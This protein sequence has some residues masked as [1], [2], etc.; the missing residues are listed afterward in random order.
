M[1][2]QGG[3]YSFGKSLPASSGWEELG[4]TDQ[5]LCGRAVLE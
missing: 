1:W 4:I 5:A 3:S 2:K